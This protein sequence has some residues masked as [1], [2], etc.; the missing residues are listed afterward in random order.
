[1][2]TR[3]IAIIIIILISPACRNREIKSGSSEPLR[4]RV[5]EVVTGSISIPVHT[6]GMLV[7]SE[8]LKLSFKTGGIVEKIFIDEGDRVKKG[9]LLASLDLSEI[10]ASAEQAKNGYEKAMRDHKRVENLFRDSAA[11]LEQKQNA[12]TALNMA[13]SAYD[14]V[15]FNLFHSRIIA[16]DNGVIMKQFV[17]EDELISSGNPVFLFG[18]SGRYW[19]VK[20]GLSDKDIIKVNRGDSAAVLFDAYPGVSF[21]AIVEQVGEM[22]NPYTGTFE[23]ELSLTKTNYRLASGFV[24]SVDIFPEVKQSFTM[25]PVG[26]IVEADGQQ[27]YIYI[28]T[29]TMTVRKIKIEIAALVGN[30]AAVKGI[31]GGITEIVSEGVAYLHD[32][33]E[34]EVVR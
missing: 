2:K 7:S 9:D 18:T 30:M 34:V 22:S 29:G 19:K 15:Q 1:M 31:P 6:S 32:G 33:V 4:I 10:K 20:A 26:S 17:R 24:A 3:N 12:E 28:V 16:P 25:V 13:K 21:S 8:E 14:I 5:A 11:T 27:G 23:T